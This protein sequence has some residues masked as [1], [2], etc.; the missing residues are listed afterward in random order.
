VARVLDRIGESRPL[1]ALIVSDN[2]PE[3]TRCDLTP[4]C[5]RL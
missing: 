2:G 1:P 5:A 4:E 3:F